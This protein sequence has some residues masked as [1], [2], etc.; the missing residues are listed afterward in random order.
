MQHSNITDSRYSWFRLS[1]TL[2]AAVIANVGIW[3]IIVIMPAVELEFAATRAEASLP[4][5]LTTC[6]R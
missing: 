1:I 4:F 5:T 6:R 2:T 3:A